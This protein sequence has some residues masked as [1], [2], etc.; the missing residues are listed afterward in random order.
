MADLH[1]LALS[2]QWSWAGPTGD[3][4]DGAA[5]LVTCTSAACMRSFRNTP[6][7]P[8]HA[9][10][11]NLVVLLGQWPYMVLS[12]CP[13]VMAILVL[14]LMLFRLHWDIVFTCYH[15]V[16]EE[17]DHLGMLLATAENKSKGRKWLTWWHLR[18]HK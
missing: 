16:L 12:V 5:S 6:P 8:S 2:H 4:H 18:L 3:D 13:Y 7:A 14:S 15:V 11:Q 1:L 9:N 17:T 10:K